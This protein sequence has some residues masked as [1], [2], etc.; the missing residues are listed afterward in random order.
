MTGTLR[1]T[2]RHGVHSIA[3]LAQTMDDACSK[4]LW[5]RVQET[6]GAAA[7]TGAAADASQA[8][9]ALSRV[10]V[11]LVADLEKSPP[12]LKV[13]LANPLMV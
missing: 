5:Q 10:P 11:H 4:A 7:R 8:I 9:T 6:G 12:N 3:H 13:V 1:I 2:W